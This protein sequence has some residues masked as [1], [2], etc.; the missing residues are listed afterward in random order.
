M[1]STSDEDEIPRYGVSMKGIH[2]FI[3]DLSKQSKFHESIN[4][5]TSTVASL[6]KEHLTKSSLS[7]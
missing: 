3:N 6:A 1:G 7:T 2:L 5:S 4:P